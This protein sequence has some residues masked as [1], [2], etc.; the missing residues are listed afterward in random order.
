MAAVNARQKWTEAVS[1]ENLLCPWITNTGTVR[2]V[3]AFGQG[4]ELKISAVKLS[5]I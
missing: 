5:K 2:A 1:L 3:D 4:L